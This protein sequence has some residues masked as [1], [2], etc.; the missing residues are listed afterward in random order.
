MAPHRRRPMSRQQLSFPGFVGRVGVRQPG[1]IRL[2]DLDS[3]GV[4]LCLG[5]RVLLHSNLP[6][7]AAC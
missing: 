2:L 4:R 7:R 3:Y 6:T 5:V 1:S